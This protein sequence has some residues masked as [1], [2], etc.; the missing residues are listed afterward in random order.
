MSPPLLERV[1]HARHPPVELLF[2]PLSFGGVRV[3]NRAVPEDPPVLDEAADQ[4]ERERER[5]VSL[6]EGLAEVRHHLVVRGLDPPDVV[7]HVPGQLGRG[8]PLRRQPEVEQHDA[9]VRSE[10]HTSELQSRQ[11]LVCRLLLE[12]KKKNTNTIIN[13]SKTTRSD[14]IIK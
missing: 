13:I 6:A 4:P 10:E 5:I 1:P 8:M 9:P 11:Y 14:N 2:R 3:H 12:K 7:H